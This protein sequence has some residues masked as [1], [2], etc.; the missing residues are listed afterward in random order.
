MVGQCLGI[1]SFGIPN[2]AGSVM[3]LDESLQLAQG[4]EP[5]F[6]PLH[7]GLGFVLWIKKQDVHI[8]KLI[9]FLD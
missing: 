3:L 8:N 6:G 2:Q 1:D 4:L 7:M 9:K 5:S